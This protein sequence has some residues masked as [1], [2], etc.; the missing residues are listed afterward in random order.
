MKTLH[1][2]EPTDKL[3]KILAKSSYSVKG[4]EAQEIQL[5]H[6]QQKRITRSLSVSKENLILP[7][8]S[9]TSIKSIS[10]G[11]KHGVAEA[12][13]AAKERI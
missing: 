5:F 7:Q 10:P 2:A 6:K 8:I 11:R 1:D 9:E 3:Q 13:F 12:I 4:K